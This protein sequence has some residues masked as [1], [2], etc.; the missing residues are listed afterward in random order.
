MV[1]VDMWIG[2]ST[3]KLMVP[4]KFEP[5]NAN[6]RGWYIPMF[7]GSKGIPAMEKYWALQGGFSKKSQKGPKMAQNSEKWL[8]MAQNG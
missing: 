4:N 6:Y 7:G 1:A 5:T 3:P 8:K 2:I